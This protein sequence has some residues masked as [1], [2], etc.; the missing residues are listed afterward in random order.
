V[1]VEDLVVSAAYR[2]R[3]LGVHLLAAIEAWGRQQGASRL[4]LLVDT[5]N[6]PAV[7][8]YD[9]LGWR[10]TQLQARWRLLPL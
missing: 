4:Q 5:A 3:G 8:F 9:H 7:G 1:W 10:R 6:T 2:G